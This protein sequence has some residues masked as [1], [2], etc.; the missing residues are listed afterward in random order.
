[1]TDVPFQGDLATDLI[2]VLAQP[3]SA[4]LALALAFFEFIV[5]VEDSTSDNG[6]AIG[7]APPD[8]ADNM[9]DKRIEVTPLSDI[10]NGVNI[11]QDVP[12]QRARLP[13]RGFRGAWGG[14]HDLIDKSPKWQNKTSRYFRRFVRSDNVEPEGQVD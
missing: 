5:D 14:Y 10:E 13:I 2:V 3:Y 12:A 4:A 7:P 9:F 8:P 6:A 1:L 11:Y